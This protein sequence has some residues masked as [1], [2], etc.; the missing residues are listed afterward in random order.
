MAIN[1]APNT[2]E[3]DASRTQL[4][5][6]TEAA[7]SCL[8]AVADATNGYASVAEGQKKLVNAV[9]EMADTLIT[10]ESRDVQLEIQLEEMKQR[11]DA[12]TYAHAER[13]D[14]N[15][16]ISDF[17]EKLTDPLADA[18]EQEVM[19]Y[20]RKRRE[21]Q[22]EE[23]GEEQA[24]SA[25]KEPKKKESKLVRDLNRFIDGID[26]ERDAFWKIFTDDELALLVEARKV[27]T[28]EEFIAIFNKLSDL[29]GSRYNGKG[30]PAQFQRDVIAAIGIVHGAKLKRILESMRKKAGTR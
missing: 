1:D 14:R 4:E 10:R 25:E 15:A 9:V 16:R 5:R 27:E 18:I 26:K 17:L 8:E 13:M 28:D 23:Q 2:N 7:I 30:G 11:R 19:D 21:E 20:V 6:A 12:I 22:G 3:G 24:A 29:L